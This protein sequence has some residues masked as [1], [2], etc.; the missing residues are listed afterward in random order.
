MEE[1]EIK[2]ECI[3]EYKECKNIKE[4][5]YFFKQLKFTNDIYIVLFLAKRTLLFHHQ[6]VYILC[7]CI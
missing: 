1:K 6:N 4:Y 5:K 2:K 7:Y 3:R